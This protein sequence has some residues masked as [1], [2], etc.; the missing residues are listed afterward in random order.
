MSDETCPH[1]NRPLTRIDHYGEELIGCVYCNCWG[2]PGD[3]STIMELL[4]DDLEAL[5][6]SVRRNQR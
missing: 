4:P 3:K 6:A 5:R 1:C 2:R